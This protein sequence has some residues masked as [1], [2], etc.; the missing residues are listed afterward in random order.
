MQQVPA[1]ID[2]ISV[3]V[4]PILAYKEEYLAWKQTKLKIKKS[5]ENDKQSDAQLPDV[6]PKASENSSSQEG[7]NSKTHYFTNGEL[8]KSVNRLSDTSDSDKEFERDASS[9]HFEKPLYDKN[10]ARSTEH[11]EVPSDSTLNNGK[12]NTVIL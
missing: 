4:I 8:E 11:R 7:D 1:T 5:C 10:E 6:N 12:E 2:D 3:F 9:D